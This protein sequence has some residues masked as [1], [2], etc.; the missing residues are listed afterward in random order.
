[1]AFD[2]DEPRDKDGKWTG[3]SARGHN[4]GGG[5]RDLALSIARGAAVGIAEGVVL[6]TVIGAVTG[7]FGSL[8]APG[9]IARAA[10]KGAIAGAR[11]PPVHAAIHA[12]L[13]AAGGYAAHKQ[14]SVKNHIVEQHI[15]EQVKKVDIFSMKN[16]KRVPFN[17]KKG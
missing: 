1:M 6:G 4:A 13:G 17:P 9:L 8:A 7:G 14:R 11:L 10:I 16:G 3:G 5:N 15:A 12:G 2:P